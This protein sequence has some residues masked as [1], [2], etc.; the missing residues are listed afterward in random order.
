MIY[1]ISTKRNLIYCI[2]FDNGMQR[3]DLSDLD[4][5]KHRI[6][7]SSYQC[8]FL[9]SHS[10]PPPL[11]THLHKLVIQVTRCLHLCLVSLIYHVSVNVSKLS[12]ISM[13]T[14]NF[15]WLFDYQ[16]KYHFY[17][18]FPLNFFVGR[19]FLQCYSK[20]LSA[21]QTQYYLHLCENW[22]ALFAVQAD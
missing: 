2:F 21:V 8:L 6:L 10:V 5:P 11:F 7:C 19:M 22:Q 18:R 13:C 14:R 15:S 12:R 17:F 16:Y 20:N 9:L 1:K 4:S 3:Q